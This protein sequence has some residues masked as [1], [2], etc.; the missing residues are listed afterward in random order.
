M[1]FF[2]W[3]IS[4]RII[5]SR[6]TYVITNVSIT[7]SWHSNIP[8]CIHLLYI[9]IYIYIY[10]H[11]NMCNIMYVCMC[12]YTHTHTHIYIYIYMGVT[13]TWTRLSHFHFFHIY[14]FTGLKQMILTFVWI[15]KMPW[16]TILRKMNKAWAITVPDFRL[17]YKVI[18]IKTWWYWQKTRDS[19][20]WIR[21]DSPEINPHAC[22]QLIYD[23][24]SKSI[25]LN[26]SCSVM[27]NSLWWHEL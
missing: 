25:K 10:T 20:Q 22:G 16:I 19:D 1:F 26:V 24:A 23:K 13:K 12:K 21:I 9:Y 8:V 27:S 3:L 7:F 17:Y 18:V 5:A 4:L 15:Y 14:I 11:T 6:P 2:L